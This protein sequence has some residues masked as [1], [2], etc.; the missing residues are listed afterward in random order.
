V[1]MFK[2]RS[3]DTANG[4]GITSVGCWMRGRNGKGVGAQTLTRVSPLALIPFAMP[5]FNVTLSSAG[6]GEE[7][8]DLIL[9]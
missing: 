6:D 7:I 4:Q 8:R 3:F 5:Y 9:G 2:P 1:M